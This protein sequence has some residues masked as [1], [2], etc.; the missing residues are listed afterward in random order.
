MDTESG[1]D[2]VYV[3][4]GNNFVRSSAR[5]FSGSARPSDQR[6]SGRDMIVAFE[7]DA[8]TLRS[9][10][11]AQARCISSSTPSSSSGSSSSSS[12]GGGSQDFDGELCRGHMLTCAF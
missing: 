4:D 12:S 5:S 3:Y 6:A 7:T 9:G 2:Y 1:W 8:N 10:W 11:S